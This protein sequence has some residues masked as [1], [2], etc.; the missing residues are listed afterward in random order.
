LFNAIY[1]EHYIT[2]KSEDE[3][4]RY[5][6][7]LLK[8]YASARLIITSRIHAALPATGMN[9]PCI[10]IKP[11]NTSEADKSRFPGLLDFLN[12]MTHTGTA[13][14]NDLH[15]NAL[16]PEIK[17]NFSEYKKLLVENLTERISAIEKHNRTVE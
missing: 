8:K 17:N 10:F 1:I 14:K 13:I 16:N 9:T 12:T 15:I 4:L 6:D 2:P 3:N 11:A 7:E 5:A